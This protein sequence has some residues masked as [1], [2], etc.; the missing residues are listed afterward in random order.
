MG[1]ISAFEAAVSIFTF[2]FLCAILCE[3]RFSP[4]ATT[5]IGI[6]FL[7]LVLGLQSVLLVQ[8]MDVP[9]LFDLLPISAFL[10][11]IV[12]LHFISADGFFPTC[13]IWSLA[14]IAVIL[15][16]LFYEGVL[17]FFSRVG[18]PE[19]QGRSI[20]TALLA[21]AA[22][23][24]LIAV[25]FF[26]KLPFHRYGKDLEQGWLVIP[27]LLVFLLLSYILN[28]L[29]SPSTIIFCLLT[30]LIAFAV[31]LRILMFSIS[32]RTTGEQQRERQRQLEFQRRDYQ[33]IRQKMELGRTYRHDMRHHFAA[34]D[35]MLQRGDDENARLCIQKLCGMLS[36]LAPESWCSNAAIDAVL[37]FYISSARDI[38]CPVDTDIRLPSKFPFDELNLCVILANG[39]ENAIH[40]CR[41]LPDG[42]RWIRLA[43]ALT[44]NRRLTISIDNPCASQVHFDAE[45]F[46]ISTRKGDS[47]GIG[48]RSIEAATKKYNGLFQCRC[49]AE[50]FHLR[51]VL[52]PLTE[53]AASRECF[54]IESLT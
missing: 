27:T 17:L 39:L 28:N 9:T 35:G 21:L 54:H 5:A 18:L 23:S 49:K 10:P 19:W 47:H 3:S 15:L 51:V 4:R 53:A 40:A 50:Q 24:A 6:S 13:A 38:N 29:S 16:K 25:A 41:E 7:A 48:L 22:A 30:A 11:M 8:G 52:F 26:L 45:G 44:E 32:L 46:P 1:I 14:G 43:V 36:D 31:L 2:F 34:L 33:A 12:C 42:E 20:G 37:S